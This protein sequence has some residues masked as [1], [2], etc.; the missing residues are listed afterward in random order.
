MRSFI[1]ELF[2]PLVYCELMTL[3][4]QCTNLSETLLSIGEGV[5]PPR[6][7]VSRSYDS[8]IPIF[9]EPP[10]WFPQ[11]LFH[12]TSPAVYTSLTFSSC[13][14]TLRNLGGGM[15]VVA[16]LVG[17]RQSCDSSDVH[18]PG[19]WWSYFSCPSDIF[20]ETMSTQL[21][22]PFFT[23]FMTLLLNL[24]GSLYTWIYDLQIFSLT[25]GYLLL[26]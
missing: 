26:Y 13:S 2:P 24:R 1:D 22:C 14:P 18:F 4:T 12:F 8:P 9:W 23:Q 25:L 3:W 19:H 16:V 20:R 7:G 5:C 10:Y 17:M 21:L 11:W 15:L 6:S